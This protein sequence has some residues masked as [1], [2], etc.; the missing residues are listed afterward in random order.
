MTDAATNITLTFGEAIKKDNQNDDFSGH[1][2]LASILTLKTGSVSGTPIPYAAT[3]NNANTVI[4]VNPSSNLADGDVYVAVSNGYYDAAGNQGTMDSATFTVDTTVPPST[5]TLTTD[6]TNNTAAE[7][8]GTVTVTATLDQP[9]D[10]GG[11]AVTLSADGTSNA[12]VTEDYTLP[13][14]FTIEEGKS[15]A[16]G[17]VTI[18]DD[19]I[20]EDNE[21]LV[22]TATV[23]GLTV[24]DATLT[25]TDNDT[26]GVRVSESSLSVLESKTQTYTVVL[27]TKPTHDVTVTPASDDEDKATVAPTAGVTFTPAGWETPKTITVTGVAAGNA[28]V[29]HAATSDDSKYPAGLS[30]ASVAVTV[31]D[32]T[33]PAAPT[34]APADG[35]TVTDAATNITLTFGE[36]IK[37]DSSGTDFSDSTSRRPISGSFF[38]INS[39][40]TLTRVD[41]IG[42]PIP[43]DAT[44]NSAKTVI[45]INPKGNLPDG[46]IYVGISKAHYD[47]NGNQGTTDSATFT[48]DATGPAQ[49]TFE[50]LDKATTTNAGTNITLTFAEAIKADDSN[51]DFTDSTI[52]S[53]LTLTTTSVSGSDIGF[54]AT[55]NT[56]NKVITI[57]PS[58]NLTEGVIYVGISNAYYDA[59]GNQGTTASATFTVDVTGVAA[60]TFAPANNETTT[61]A[62]T[63][64]T[65]TFDEA[66]KADNSNT[67][68]TDSTIDSIL[69]LTRDNSS[70]TD[71]GFDATINAT[72]TVITINPTSDLVDG[73]IYVGISNAYYDAAG[74]QGTTFSATFTVDATGPAQPTFEPLD[75]ATVTNAGTNIT[76]TFAEAIKKDNQNGDFSGHADLASILTLKTTS[77][78]GSP[79][80]YA[81]SIGS[82][83]KVITIDPSSNLADGVIYVAVSNGYYD[84]HGNQG[85]MASATFTVDVTGV[86]APTFDPANNETTTDAG[87]NIT[88]TFDE[89][90]KADNS[91]NDFTDSTIDGILTLSQTN[92]SGSAIGFDA[93][94]NSANTIITINPTSNLAEG[95]IYVG[96]S[97]AYYDANGNQGAMASATFTVDTTGPAQPTFDPLDNATVTNAGR[98]ITLT[99]AE[100][101]KA[102]NSNNDFTDSTIDGILTLT[103]DNSSG[104]DIGFD[105]TINSANT[106][107]TIN[108]TSDLPEDV[109]YV[110]I[111]NA[112]YYD[113]NGNQG[114]TASAT[115]TVDTTGPAQPTFDPLD[116]DEPRRTRA[117]TSR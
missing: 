67:D 114:T 21:T 82:E 99:F 84:E 91:N 101:I 105:A 14:A 63:N 20:D 71:I 23:S 55:I 110:G 69:T 33:G 48:V 5:L 15:S 43:Y 113:A 6:A 102:D 17:D 116:N 52:D 109:I 3:I 95:V 76:L 81:A 34:F 75:N 10:T 78:S 36:A 77:V 96:I 74:N 97:N 8:A 100:A 39:I 70:G 112:Y 30:I 89:A 61:D 18:V 41:S 115:F 40:L 38:R 42:T 45:T 59:N 28:T 108:P 94:I 107:I 24:T 16:T 111:S 64:I 26:A 106:I 86:A 19:D 11:V 50:P 13:N 35:V 57:D 87:T 56:A 1:A 31:T 32:T 88:L 7:D 103:R 85:T 27:D 12:T 44:I 49:P 68:F 58:S 22:L 98:N 4:T 60:P 90:I 47:A 117:P 93:T 2:D 9:A 62:G 104:S 25:I 53:I 46:V 79:I 92:S 72:K 66:I 65:L 29:T 51:N 73:V 37:A 54:D 83:N 80:P